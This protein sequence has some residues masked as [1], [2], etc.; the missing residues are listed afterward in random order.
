MLD[1]ATMEF[2]REDGMVELGTVGGDG[3]GDGQGVRRRRG[4]AVKHG[5]SALEAIVYLVD[6][7]RVYLLRASTVTVVLPSLLLA[8]PSMPAVSL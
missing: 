3:G 5:F 2:D 6:A 1:Y 7:D 8:V 4:K